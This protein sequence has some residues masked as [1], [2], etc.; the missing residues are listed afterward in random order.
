MFEIQNETKWEK[1]KDFLYYDIWV[2]ISDPFKNW[3]WPAYKVRRLCDR[4]DIVKL[5]GLK[6]TEW[7]DVVE[8]M[9]IAN[10][11]LIKYFIE[12]EKP[13]EHVMWYEDSDGHSVG[14]KYG[15]C[16]DAGWPTFMP[17]YKDMYILDLIKMIYVWYTVE[18]PKLEEENKYLLHFWSDYLYG[19]PYCVK[20]EKGDYYEQKLDK[21]SVP[22]E[23]SFFNDK[24]VNWFILDKYVDGN[25]NN[26]LNEKFI[27]DKM[28]KL[29]EKI[30]L[31]KTKMLHLCA[32]VRM[33]LWT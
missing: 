25:R 16:E 19:K 5:P 18:Q 22:T 15:E 23:M 21:S 29:D 4:H 20:S 6:A 24:N 2:R 17:E 30:E 12:V 9:Y 11:E 3:I 14:Q 13:E 32:E 8:R 26:V 33:Y 27:S 31:E 10:M 1:F 7:C 28:R